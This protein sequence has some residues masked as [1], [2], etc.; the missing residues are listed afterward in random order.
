MNDP[1]P[2][3]QVS[4]WKTRLKRNG[5]AV[6]RA[7]KSYSLILSLIVLL[8]VAFLWPRIFI[9][10]YPGEN[11]VLWRRFVGGTD[12]R[13]PYGEGLHILW[14]WDKMHI[15]DTRIQQVSHD[16][17][18]LSRSGL[19][20]RFELSIRY[21]PQKHSLP[22]L[23]QDIGPDYVEKVVKPEVQTYV[24][25][26]V[27]NYLPEEIYTSEGLLL[28][29]I[30]QGALAG[31]DR[32]NIVLDDLLIKRMELPERIREAIEHKLTAEQQS[33]RY[34]F[35]LQK[36]AKEADRKRIEAEGIR[37]FQK[38]VMTGGAFS[39]YLN[40]Q[41]ILATLELAQ[42]DNSKVVVLGNRDSGGLPL[43][44]SLPLDESASTGTQGENGN[45]KQKDSAG[46]DSETGVG[47]V[48]DMLNPSTRKLL[49]GMLS[50]DV[51]SPVEDASHKTQELIS[52]NP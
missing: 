43:L 22:R 33:L 47:R 11:G 12:L 1:E 44:F 29:I 50:P 9:N 49:E 36:E 34:D 35:L 24:R 14:P 30:K 26:V 23:H 2:S 18:A 38:I 31:L 3:D 21:R 8:T 6:Y 42:S 4:P 19:P 28:Q 52:L 46:D 5:N 25:E 45:R 13:Y 27:A 20:I 48:M 41:G 16:F 32:R 37:D 39:E 17:D 7:I 51:A 40:F 10:V 15:Y